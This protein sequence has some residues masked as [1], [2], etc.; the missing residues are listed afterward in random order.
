MA[1]NYSNSR[2]EWRK[3]NP[4]V[5]ITQRSWSNYEGD[6]PY[7]FWVGSK[8]YRDSSKYGSG[9]SGSGDQTPT[10]DRPTETGGK[11]IGESEFERLQREVA[12]RKKKPEE[13]SQWEK[14]QE[15]SALKRGMRSMQ[16][17][18]PIYGMG[19]TMA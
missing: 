9:G 5:N 11:S 13:K 2:A 14:L 8:L 18:A 7:K 10:M 15:E 17:N 19:G 12:E 3:A 6:N 4:G 1:S 16:G